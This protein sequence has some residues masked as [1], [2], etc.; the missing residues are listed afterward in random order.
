MR[1]FAFISPFNHQLSFL[2]C[3]DNKQ[4][5][6]CLKFHGPFWLER[7]GAVVG[8]GCLRGSMAVKEG[9]GMRAWGGI[10]AGKKGIVGGEGVQMVRGVFGSFTEE[11]G[12]LQKW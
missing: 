8:R 6:H 5:Y 7:R 1:G 2:F 4:D 10:S 3:G 9:R 11:V 12:Y